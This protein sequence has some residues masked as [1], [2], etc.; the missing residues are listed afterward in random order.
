ME[1]YKNNNRY[2]SNK[3]DD[4]EY[5][6]NDC[7]SDVGSCDVDYANLGGDNEID[8]HAHVLYDGGEK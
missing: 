7:V 4:T 5:I 6:D 3:I 8:E 1:L 2:L